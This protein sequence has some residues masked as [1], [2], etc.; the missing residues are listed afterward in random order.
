MFVEKET[1]YPDFSESSAHLP[2][3]V[4]LEEDDLKGL[5]ADSVAPFLENIPALVTRLLSRAEMM[6]NP[7]AIDAVKAEA[8]GLDEG[9]WDPNTVVEK[10]EVIGR[11]LKA[12]DK[13]HLRDLMSICSEKLVNSPLS[14]E[15]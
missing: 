4:L 14:L 10:A 12:G 2:I 3:A 15:S 8:K 13:I 1:R 7:K 5:S 9:T 11:A 6:S